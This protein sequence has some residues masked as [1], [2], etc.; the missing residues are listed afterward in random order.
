MTKRTPYDHLPLMPSVVAET[1]LD[2]VYTGA[3]ISVRSRYDSLVAKTEAARLAM[4]PEQREE[5]VRLA[6]AKCRS[7]YEAKG[8]FFMKIVRAKGN[9]GRAQLYMWIRHWLCSYLNN[10]ENLRRA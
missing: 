9:S 8:D 2:E 1:V 3:E 6:D 4:T 10:P 7:A 5:F